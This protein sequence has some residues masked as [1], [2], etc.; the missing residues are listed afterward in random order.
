MV[1]IEGKCGVS[2]KVL[3]DSISEA[4]V[5]LL[6]FEITYWRGI[7]AELNTHRMLSRS[8]ASSR[9]IPFKKMQDNLTGR[10]VRFGEANPGMQDKG[11][12]FD[13]VIMGRKRVFGQLQDDM[14]TAD[15]AWEEARKDASFWSKAFFEAG[16]HKQV[17]NRL[18][19]SSQMVKTVISGTEW[20]N[21]FWLRDDDA[22]DPSI[23]ELA[24]C[25]RE[26]RDASTPQL[27]RA[28]EWHLPYVNFDNIQWQ[29]WIDD[30]AV[31]CRLGQRYLTT[32]EAI[33]VSCARSAAVSFR[34]TDYGLEKCLEV[35]ERLVGDER[36]HAS[37][38]EHQATPVGPFVYE[39]AFENAATTKHINS[40]DKSHTWQK[41][42][43]H[44]DR[45]GDFWSGNFRGWI[46]HR[47]TVDG[48]NYTG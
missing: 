39:F 40:V 43:S 14:L 23:A 30:S 34:N 11:D 25:M 12:D 26:A 37:A 4:G 16:F 19:E 9:A 32:E 47:K 27:L 24:R 46:Q 38:L 1:V 28:G 5:R 6:T 45:K 33:K 20:D 17:Y 13:G 7:L 44:V 41:G 31:E 42:I 36:K 8:S 29:H 22:A 10:P 35:Y 48:E 15:E 3:C 21:F 18:V 2:A